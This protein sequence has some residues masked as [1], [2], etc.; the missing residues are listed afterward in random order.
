MANEGRNNFQ[1]EW[2]QDLKDSISVVREDIR[3]VRTN[4]RDMRSEMSNA[5]EDI[6]EVKDALGG[7]NGIR[8]RLKEVELV[9]ANLADRETTPVS[10]VTTTKKASTKEQAAMVG[11]AGSI[12]AI[13]LYML[14]LAGE[15]LKTK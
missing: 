7:N 11:G 3:D 9:V 10:I 2:V 1:P 4:V 6:D 14:Q 15:Y 8:E 12:G 5:R 13:I